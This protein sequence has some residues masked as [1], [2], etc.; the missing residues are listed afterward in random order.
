LQQSFTQGNAA[1][2]TPR[3]SGER[4]VVELALNEWRR[5]VLKWLGDELREAG[6]ERIAAADGLAIAHRNPGEVADDVV[7][8]LW[9]DLETASIRQARLERVITRIEQMDL[10]KLLVLFS[11]TTKL[12]T[13]PW[14]G[15]RWQ[16]PDWNF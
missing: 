7:A 14:E 8:V 13:W 5:Q 2:S 9:D 6:Q 15:D 16:L 12:K 1:V 3:I 11:R 4:V 10:S